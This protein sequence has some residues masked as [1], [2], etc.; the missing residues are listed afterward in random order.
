MI[1]IAIADDH[2]LFIDGIKALLEDNPLMQVIGEAHNGVEILNV[3]KDSKPDVVLLDV[4]MPVLDGL[5]V[6]K[7]LKEAKNAVKVIMLTMHN[8]AD[9]IQ[10]LLKAGAD[11]YIIKN[12]GKDE[13]TTGIQTVMAGK[14]FF[15]REVTEVIMDRLQGKKTPASTKVELTEREVDVLR[16]IVKEHTTQEIADLLFISAS[17]VETHRKNLISKLGVRNLAEL[18]KYALQN[19][20][21]EG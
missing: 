2:Q 13:L 5:A 1:K 18:V 16:L 12:S 15:S 20:L 11:G 17:T 3:V 10:K 7:S 9:N 8:F 6:L 21:V 19:G 14:S 4:N